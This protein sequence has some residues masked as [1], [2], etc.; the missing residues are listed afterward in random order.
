MAATITI[1]YLG[2]PAQA[3]QLQTALAE[4]FEDIQSAWTVRV[5]GDAH[6]T[7]WEVTVEAPDGTIAGVKKFYGED[8]T[9]N[10][11]A[12]VGYVDLITRDAPRVRHTAI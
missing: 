8:G 1:K 11:E 5:L 2:D 10:V 7:I 12:I 9:H 6:S 3:A 4:H